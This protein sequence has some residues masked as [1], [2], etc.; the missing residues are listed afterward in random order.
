[1]LEKKLEWYEDAN[2]KTRKVDFKKQGICL[3][4]LDSLLDGSHIWNAKLTETE[5]FRG[6]SSWI[7]GLS[8]SIKELLNLIRE[9]F[10]S[11]RELSIYV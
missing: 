2:N 10:K 5:I 11:I 3:F 6:I 7:K 8:N 4:S 9:H 1:M